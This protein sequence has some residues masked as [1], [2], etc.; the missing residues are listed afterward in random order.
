MARIESALQ[1]TQARIDR[2]GRANGDAEMLHYDPAH[3]TARGFRGTIA[4]GTMLIAPLFDLA[5]RR[6]GAGFLS[7]GSLVLKWT[8]PVCAGDVQLASIDDEGRIEAVIENQP[9]RPASIRGEAHCG[10]EGR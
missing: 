4:H 1:V 5:L 6:F 2:Y 8:A 10:G 7:S 9:G 3:A